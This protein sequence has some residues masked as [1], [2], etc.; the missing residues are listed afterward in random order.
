MGW[1]ITLNIQNF[2]D[3]IPLEE[4]FY[5]IIIRIKIICR[6]H[7]FNIHLCVLFNYIFALTALRISTIAQVSCWQ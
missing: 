5:G 4:R 2:P 7:V 1:F 6:K 3:I